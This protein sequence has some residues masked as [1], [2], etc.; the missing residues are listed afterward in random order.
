M[1]W[2]G[3]LKY[4]QLGQ[5]EIKV[6]EVGLGGAGIG[7]AWG[8]TSDGEC[9][10]LINCAID[11][12]INFYDTSPVYGNE[13]SEINLGNV[14]KK[15]SST[16]REKLIIAT[17]IRFHDFEQLDKIEDSMRSSIDRSLSNLN[18]DYIDLI[19]IHHQVGNSRGEYKFRDNPPEFAPI[20]TYSDCINF[21][22]LIS[23]FRAEGKVRF[24]GLT[25]WNADFLTIC[26]LLK[27]KNFDTIQVLYNVLNQSAGGK[28]PILN[29]KDQGSGLN[30]N[31]I[32]EGSIFDLCQ[33]Y[34]VGVIGIR[35]HAAGAIVNQLD[36]TIHLKDSLYQ[37]HKNA[38]ELDDVAKKYN[39]SLAEM[40]L[41]FCIKN[42]NISTTV[43]GV[44]NRQELMQS[45]KCANSRINDE[46]IIEI[47]E[48]YKR[49][50]IQD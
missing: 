46:I 41:I 12:G 32:N 17:K 36:R 28:L 31:S 1:N 38:K 25:G 19:Q 15:L 9:Q 29:E 4:N 42:P 26:N 39:L 34:N 33:K 43:P 2:R 37:M 50:V 47:E 27:S 22:D 24:T 18:L 16:R 23:R 11:N 5:T 21:S 49:K 10:Y 30:D 7:H 44:K 3:V 35:S 45:I 6:S 8:L 48:W 40:A 14:F 20:M 13:K